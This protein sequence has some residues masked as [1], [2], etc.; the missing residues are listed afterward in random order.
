MP[1]PVKASVVLNG[2]HNLGNVRF[3]MPHDSA[4]GSGF[5]GAGEGQT[6]F[7]TVSVIS[8]SFGNIICLGRLHALHEG[9]WFINMVLKSCW[10]FWVCHCAGPVCIG[11]PGPMTAQPNL[12]DTHYYEEVRQF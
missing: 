9:N 11:G 6:P 3:T 5:G 1:D 8:L 7:I 2:G 12:F 10:V 4:S